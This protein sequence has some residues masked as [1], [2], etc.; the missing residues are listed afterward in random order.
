MPLRAQRHITASASRCMPVQGRDIILITTVDSR[1]WVGPC[2][3]EDNFL[4][5]T[6]PPDTQMGVVEIDKSTIQSRQKSG[7]TT[8]E[9]EIGACVRE[10]HLV[11]NWQSVKV[12]V[13]YTIPVKHASMEATKPSSDLRL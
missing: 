9:N 11:R 8:V 6:A 1:G 10:Q 2:E 3:P 12:K 4:S 7:E 5:H 13:N